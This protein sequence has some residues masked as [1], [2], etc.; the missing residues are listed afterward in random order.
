MRRTFRICSSKFYKNAKVDSQS[1][2]QSKRLTQKLFL[3]VY[4]L[5]KI[6]YILFCIFYYNLIL[7]SHFNQNNFRLT[8]LKDS[9]KFKNN[10]LTLL[11]LE[12]KLYN[13]LKVIFYCSCYIYLL[14]SSVMSTTSKDPFVVYILFLYSKCYFFFL[15]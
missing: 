9:N 3:Y 7:K 8:L 13:F 2:I 1:L 12:I 10:W 14:Y 4:L 5:H 15:Y 11:S 6:L